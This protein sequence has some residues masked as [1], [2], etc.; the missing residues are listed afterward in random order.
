MNVVR[1]IPSR[2]RFVAFYLEDSGYWEVRIIDQAGKF[3]KFVGE[4]LQY[5]SYTAARE[6]IDMLED[7]KVG[8]FDA[9]GSVI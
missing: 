6:R 1:E 3:S 9:T 7:R 5:L 8:V 4:S 2:G